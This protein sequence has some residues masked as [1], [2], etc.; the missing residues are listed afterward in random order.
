MAGDVIVVATGGS[1]GHRGVIALDTDGVV[2]W[3]VANGRHGRWL[4]TTVGWRPPPGA[5]LG[6]GPADRQEPDPPHRVLREIFRGRRW[7]PTPS[8]RRCR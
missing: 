5:R 4:A 8:R 2:D 7:S 3:T 6:P 1:T